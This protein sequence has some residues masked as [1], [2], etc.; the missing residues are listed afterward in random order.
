MSICLKE[1]LKQ[2]FLIK[3]TVFYQSSAGN[4]PF[5]ALNLLVLYD[6]N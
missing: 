3:L 6:D 2:R 4:T 5:S 1:K